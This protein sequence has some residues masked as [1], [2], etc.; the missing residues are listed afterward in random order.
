MSISRATDS[1]NIVLL[2][3]DKQ[4]ARV[5]EIYTLLEVR[6]RPHAI[7]PW[8]ASRDM[9]GFGNL[10]DNIEDAIAG[11]L[12]AIVFLGRDGLGRF[13][14]NIE[15]GMVST[16]LWQQGA[17]YGALLVHLESGVDVPRPLLRWVSTN[18]DGSLTTAAECVDSILQRFRLDKRPGD[19]S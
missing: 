19:S 10:F 14:Q 5:E 7:R 1:R 11:A 3:N 15:M 17:A 2:Y 6:L 12:G 8:M 9:V 13:Q 16:E 18:H 4:R